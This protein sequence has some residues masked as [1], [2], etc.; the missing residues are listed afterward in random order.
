MVSI[1]DFNKTFYCFSFYNGIVNK[2]KIGL[3][4]EDV[5]LQ[6]FYVLK[7][8]VGEMRLISKE[9][10]FYKKLDLMRYLKKKS[11]KNNIV[12]LG[13]GEKVNIKEIFR[14]IKDL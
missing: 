7:I 5:G 10:M 9:Y 8:K 2:G 11:S 13:N 1:D 14:K 6:R 12:F 3:N 4:C